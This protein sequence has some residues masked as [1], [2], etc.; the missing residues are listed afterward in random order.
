MCFLPQTS[1]L[2]WLFQCITTDYRITYRPFLANIFSTKSSGWG[3]IPFV[4][5]FPHLYHL[6]SSKSCMI[7]DILVGPDNLV[8][9]S[10]GFCSNLSN[11]ERME[12]ASL[13]WLLEGC[14]F[15]EGRRMFVFGTLILVGVL[16]VKLCLI[17]CWI[18][19]PYGVGF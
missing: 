6:Y 17:C 19:P 5:Y 15:R 12:V 7:S 18:L 16:L 13:L 9:F 10:F 11:R 14:C 4:R 3:R 2:H 1:Y 8:S